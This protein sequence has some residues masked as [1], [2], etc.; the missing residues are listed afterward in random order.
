MDFS[1]N[2]LEAQRALE[3]IHE[4]G[5]V[6]EARAFIGEGEDTVVRSTFVND[7]GVLARAVPALET[8]RAQV[9]VTLNPVHPELF[10]RAPNKFWQ[11]D[12]AGDTDIARRRWILLDVDPKRPS[13]TSST[14]QEKSLSRR[15][16]E[17][18]VDGLSR[19]LG[20]GLP[21]VA[22]SGNG[23]HLLYRIDLPNDAKSREPVRAALVAL[24][25][26]VG[27]D[28]VGV[29]KSVFNAARLVTLY[30]TWK[31]KGED[32]PERP[33][34][35]SRVLSV[36]DELVVVPREKLEELAALAPKE[37]P[38][39]APYDGPAGAR[40]DLREFLAKHDIPVLRERPWTT[41]EGE[42]VMLLEV[43]CS[44]S[45]DDPHE[46]TQAAV[47]QAAGG[48]LFARCLHDRCQGKGWQDFRAIH[49]A[50]YRGRT[51]QVIGKIDAR[52]CV[53]R[54]GKENTA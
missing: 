11:R 9:F 27:S 42:P 54:S 41:P 31:R 2:A 51:P 3:I 15:V 24:D 35:Q 10:G 52:P 16:A 44:F 14:N 29:D 20:W 38:T 36:P 43:P 32:T 34:R 21:I 39:T 50:G 26:Q 33:H 1:R 18:I 7:P 30:G 47:W 40:L 5:E 23:Y 37:K 49:D 48:K 22:D 4:P 46:G 28:R 8:D 45:P 25:H 6:R 17:N 53:L 13:D 19:R 12:A